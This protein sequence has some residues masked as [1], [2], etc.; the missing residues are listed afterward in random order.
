M[1]NIS[2]S[3]TYEHSRSVPKSSL[4]DF[5]KKKK[6][7]GEGTFGSVSLYEGPQGNMAV[8]K[9]KLRDDQFPSTD[10]M[11]EL[12]LLKRL[13]HRNIVPI[14]GYSVDLNQNNFYIALEAAD[15]DL[16]RAIRFG[17]FSSNEQDSL[18]YQMLNA[19]AY[20]HSRHI[21]HR[22]I[23]PQNFLFKRID[24]VATI[25][26]ADFGA[27]KTHVCHPNNLWTDIVYTLW[28]RPPEV[29]SSTE[30][31]ANYDFPADIWALGLSI[32]EVYTGSPLFHG[33]GENDQMHQIRTFF[34][35]PIDKNLNNA[36][37]INKN[38]IIGNI[39]NKMIVLDPKNRATA[40]ELEKDHYFD[41]YRDN[42]AVPTECSVS[43]ATRDRY[44]KFYAPVGSK[45]YKIR[46]ILIDWLIDVFLMMKLRQKTLQITIALLDQVTPLFDME[47]INPIYQTLGIA[48]MSIA[49]N[50][51][52]LYAPEMN[53]YIYIT[54]GSTDL[55]SLNAIR[56]RVINLLNGDLFFTV[57][58]DYIDEAN[59]YPEKCW[60][61]AKALMIY[62][63]FDNI[64]Y[65]VM[66]QDVF[67]FAMALSIKFYKEGGI[68]PRMRR[69][70][71][72]YGPEF[73]KTLKI[74]KRSTL[75]ANARYF[76]NI[77][78]S[79]SVT[80]TDFI[81]IMV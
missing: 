55:D 22:D 75:K 25:W 68:N 80:V 79:T 20:I 19:V 46:S 2:Y 35:D 43:H 56:I 73:I 61:L 62:M 63:H 17:A 10:A 74:S 47:N 39:I 77:M 26:L 30:G 4:D 76:N 42:D 1:D 60:Q 49:A 70:M 40:Y 53:D 28:Y 11:I 5:G 48:C 69:L 14:L 15:S 72:K 31:N 81:N 21:M 67:Y 16:A 8:K 24:G 27:S 52:E 34:K 23:K 59:A 12:M 54:D 38:V 45:M 36:Q 57:P 7:L 71:K 13:Q 50:L 6:K 41:A 3:E 32:Y 29:L 66:P 78:K 44:G 18:T 65:E 58:Y 9:Y 64:I 37:F 33:N 51:V